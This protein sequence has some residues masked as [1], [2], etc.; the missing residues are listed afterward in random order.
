MGVADSQQGY[1]TGQSKQYRARQRKG[2]RAEQSQDKARDTGQQRSR[3]THQGRV[4]DRARV[5]GKESIY[6]YTSGQ[7]TTRV[8]MQ[9][10][11]RVTGTKLMLQ[12]R[13]DLEIQYRTGIE[14]HRGKT[15]PSFAEPK[16]R[17]VCDVP[18]DIWITEA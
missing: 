6:G 8:T 2:Y 1:R 13:T 4:R 18:H 3:V 17:C 12:D 15:K 10:R 9:D 5:T 7:N 11:G 14:L 16:T